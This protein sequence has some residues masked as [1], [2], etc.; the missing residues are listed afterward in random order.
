MWYWFDVNAKPPEYRLV[1]ANWHIPD[2]ASE[3][4]NVRAHALREWRLECK[5]LTDEIEAALDHMTAV[6]FES[7]GDDDDSSEDEE[8]TEK[9]YQVAAVAATGKFRE[10]GIGQSVVEAELRAGMLNVL[11]GVD[12]GEKALYFQRNITELNHRHTA[13]GLFVDLNPDMSPDVDAKRQLDELRRAIPKALPTRNL[14][15]YDCKWMNSHEEEDDDDT[16][17]TDRY[18]AVAAEDV[19]RMCADIRQ[20]LVDRLE[21]SVAFKP[22][23]VDAL[24]Q[25]LM[26]QSAYFDR[27]GVNC[28]CRD[29]SVER[30][31]FYLE[32]GDG[33]SSPLVL[34]GEPGVGKTSV[35]AHVSSEAAVA[36]ASG[37][38]AEG[39]PPP[40]VVARFCGVT[41][42]SSHSK[43]LLRGLCMQ[44]AAYCSVPHPGT[45][46]GGGGGNHPGG[47]QRR[48]SQV[49][50]DDVHHTSDV[51]DAVTGRL[52]SVLA[53]K[54]QS[55]RSVKVTPAEEA[56]AASASAA[57]AAANALG[58]S[59]A[60]SDTS[61]HF[62]LDSW[63]RRAAASTG[64]AILVFIDGLEVGLYKLNPFAP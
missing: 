15:R 41:E 52:S 53:T 54:Q 17:D 19:R 42:A 47:R 7:T 8:E 10:R 36:A 26:A 13:A 6:E 39:N 56:D 58:L 3:S 21:Q 11:D 16:E 44:L 12:V 29:A 31:K 63:L 9:R 23:A 48:S 14:Y 35:M 55:T 28:F 20:A 37:N 34:Y 62:D 25:E 43:S 49:D 51:V 22:P 27:V 33:V 32:H 60:I 4:R 38:D 40:L 46:V 1:P 2:M 30:V 45:A 18:D 64:R 5:C 57:T 61:R 59:T 24:G 50:T